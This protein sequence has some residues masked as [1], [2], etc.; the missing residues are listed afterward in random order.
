MK[1]K[2]VKDLITLIFKALTLAMGVAVVALSIMNKIDG[3]G[4]F[5]YY[6]LAKDSTQVW[7]VH[8]TG[9]EVRNILTRYQMDSELFGADNQALRA[10]LDL[11][12]MQRQGIQEGI[13]NGATYR[14]MAT[15]S[16]WSKDEDLARERKRFDANNFRG[17]AG[18][19]PVPDDVRLSDHALISSRRIPAA[20]ASGR[21]LP[22]RPGR[23]YPRR[24]SACRCQC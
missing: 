9:R 11:I 19:D 4:E 16:N 23:T 1:E 10:T 12:E 2:N 6:Y 3:Y 5:P 15:S 18:G 17:G 14:F 24:R 13:K 22:H 20:R 7:F 8:F 21:P